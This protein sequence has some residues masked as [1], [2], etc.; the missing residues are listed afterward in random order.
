MTSL[1]TNGRLANFFL[2]LSSFVDYSGWNG[3]LDYPESKIEWR[4]RQDYV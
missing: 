2:H 1:L 3:V 4:S